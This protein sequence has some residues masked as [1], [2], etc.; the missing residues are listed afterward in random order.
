MDAPLEATLSDG[1]RAPKEV[2]TDDSEASA[3]EKNVVLMSHDEWMATCEQNQGLNE[4]RHSTAQ[5]LSE[6]QRRHAE[7]DEEEAIRRR[8]LAHTYQPRG[9]SELTRDIY[10]PGESCSSY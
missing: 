9:V 1:A 5:E 3:A 7:E 8:H 4:D 10:T 6:D 2:S